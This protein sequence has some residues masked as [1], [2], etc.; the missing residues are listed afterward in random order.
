MDILEYVPQRKLESGEWVPVDEFIFRV[1]EE[2]MAVMYACHCIR[3]KSME[4]A[5]ANLKN[6]VHPEPMKLGGKT[7]IVE[8]KSALSIIKTPMLSNMTG[9]TGS[10]TAMAE[11]QKELPNHAEWRMK[12]EC[13]LQVL[14]SVGWLASLTKARPPELTKDTSSADYEVS[15][16]PGNLEVT[17]ESAPSGYNKGQADLL[18]KAKDITTDAL[19]KCGVLAEKLS[20]M[21]VV[22]Y[23]ELLFKTHARV[24]N[25][26]PDPEAE[27]RERFEAMRQQAI[28]AKSGDD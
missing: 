4:E 21:G 16:L 3:Y 2:E 27:E 18:K 22:Q 11:L 14:A 8:I 12:K 5:E 6:Y 19:E 28:A 7:K 25:A 26:L 24:F 1:P 20:E 10:Q 23:G 13:G 9:E 17:E 15:L